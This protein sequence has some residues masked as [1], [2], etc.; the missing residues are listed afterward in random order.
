MITTHSKNNKY[1]SIIFIILTLQYT[2]FYYVEDQVLPH[3]LLYVFYLT[4]LLLLI[5]SYQ[6]SV[7]K[8]TPYRLMF[9]FS[10]GF[11]LLASIFQPMG[12]TGDMVS[13]FA[14]YLSILTAFWFSSISID[15]IFQ[16]LRIVAI[17]GLI[18]FIY[19]I[20][21]SDVDLATALN[22][23]YTWTE[24]FYY[25]PIFWAVIPFVILAFIK[26][27]NIVLS[28][29]YWG[30]AIILNLLFLKRAILVDSLI[31]LP[32]LI[33]INYHKEKK[34]IS[35]LKLVIIVSTLIGFTLYF[36]SDSILGLF[37]ATNERMSESSDDISTFNRLVESENHF[38]SKSFIEVLIGNGFFGQH[39]G[40]GK[41]ANALHIGWA[42]FL[43]KGGLLLSIL[44]LIPFLKIIKIIRKF[45]IL[46]L[47]IKF[48]IIFLLINIPRLLYVNTHNLSPYMLLMFYSI[49]KIMDFKD[50]EY[51]VN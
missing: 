10:Y 11:I 39:Y 4:T 24:I 8:F 21:I 3:S 28:L 38:N 16:L 37:D 9:I 35:G 36:F 20:I 14:I 48:S 33:F 43:F 19:I 17:L 50:K 27:E 22:R 45:R 30:C 26:S 7:I 13:N 18:S 5:L 51:K 41:V 34:L 6:K 46:P 15:V 25:G 47:E 40:L 2:V 12:E 32:A 23:G 1:F 42:N 44:I 29:V 49:F 31:L